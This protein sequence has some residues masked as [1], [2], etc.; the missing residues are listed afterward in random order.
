MMSQEFKFDANSKCISGPRLY[1][2][3]AEGITMCIQDSTNSTL[4]RFYFDPDPKKHHLP[5]GLLDENN[6]LITEGIITPEF[7]QQLKNQ[8]HQTSSTTMDVN[9]SSIIEDLVLSAE[10]SVV[11]SNRRY[12]VKII[13][14]TPSL[15]E[16]GAQFMMH[17]MVM[18]PSDSDRFI[19]FL[20]Q[21]LESKSTNESKFELFF[22]HPFGSNHSINDVKSQ[23]LMKPALNDS[24]LLT[25]ETFQSMQDSV[26]Q[27]FQCLFTRQQ[28]EEFIGFQVNQTIRPQ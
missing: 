22:I 12:V 25:F 7:V 11:N 1:N 16:T 26:H 15:I 28:I 17:Q 23:V 4:A 6:C 2:L 5:L 13:K 14:Q 9:Q 10:E 21:G 3:S 18:Y 19:R 8:L 20:V 27:S 24:F